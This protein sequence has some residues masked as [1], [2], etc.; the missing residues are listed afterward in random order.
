[1]AADRRAP[2]SKPARSGAP[3]PRTPRIG[4]AE[5]SRRWLANS[6]AATHV[7]NGVNLLFPAGERF[8]VRSVRHYLDRIDDDELRR[9]VKGFFGQEGRHA[10][11]HER[12]FETLRAQGYDVDR[13]LA[14]YER[15][16][17]GFVERLS[18][19][20]L[21]LAVTVALEHFTAILAEDALSG[22]MLGYA[23]PPM[24]RLLQW[25]ALEEL[26]HKAVAF[27]V[28]VA[29]HPSYALRV[30][31]LGLATALLAA[32]WLRATG[33]LLAQDGKTLRDAARELSALRAERTSRGDGFPRPIAQRVFLRGIR[34]YLRP[35]F[36]PLD[37]DHT[38]LVAAA[39][40]ALVA[41]GVVSPSDEHA[42]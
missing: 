4:F 38:A 26:E 32:F 12:F 21:R 8:F 16:A 24:R 14:R 41:E 3:L 34:E 23:E 27:D 15:F 9:Q 36:H 37:R 35:G 20:A 5:V 31:G 42:A 2:H 17:F 29:V 11:T 1:V 33:E 30:A 10:H 19:P 13:F 7:A 22:P 18:P 25:H 39:L 40:S 6:V 28:L